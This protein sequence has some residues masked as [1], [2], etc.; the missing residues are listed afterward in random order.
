MNMIKTSIKRLVATLGYELKPLTRVDSKCEG[1][2]YY[3]QSAQAANMDVN[4]WLESVLKW[5]DGNEIV[6]KH[7]LPHLKEGSVVCEVGSGTGRHAKH[8]AE[9]LTTGTLHLFDH[10]VYLQ[11]FL[12]DYFKNNSSVQIHESDGLRI[13]LANDSVDLVFSTGTFVALKL[14][15]IRL[16]AVEFRRIC[17]PGATVVINYFD[18]ENEPAW[19]HLR[20]QDP[21]L[22]DTYTYHCGRTI[23]AVFA[24]AGFQCCGHVPSGHSTYATFQ[25][26]SNSE[27]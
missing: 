27:R 15:T 24:E 23:E 2:D 26:R 5:P 6:N 13:D 19:D 7:V 20:H 11:D 8:I 10:S 21:S 12:A 3:V 14:G 25:I 4:D 9:H 16:L 1:F 22:A 17:Q 18:I